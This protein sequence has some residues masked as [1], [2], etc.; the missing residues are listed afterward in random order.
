MAESP[1]SAPTLPTATYPVRTAARASGREP[2]F[3][4]ERLGSEC[5]D[6]QGL[7]EL[8]VNGL[9]AITALRRLPPAA[10]WC[11]TWTGCDLTPPAVACA[12][13]R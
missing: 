6:L 9:D 8:T 4:L 13:C 10:G 5:T 2:D 11:G 1:L 7:R 3:L 12:S